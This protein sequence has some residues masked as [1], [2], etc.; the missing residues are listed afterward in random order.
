LVDDNY[1]WLFS[2]AAQSI[3]ALIG[4]LLAGVAL[5][6]S[7]MDRL[8]EQHETREETVNSYRRTQHW[9]LTALAILTGLAILASLYAVLINP[10]GM[11]CRDIVRIIAGVLDVLAII[12]SI[13]FVSFIVRPDRYIKAAKHEYNKIRSGEH[14]KRPDGTKTQKRVE[15][16][17]AFFRE[18]IELEQS[19]RNYIVKLNFPFQH[20]GAKPQMSLREMLE[21]LRQIEKISQPLMDQL[22]TVNRLRNLIFHGRMESVDEDVL[23]MLRMAR[24]RWDEETGQQY[25]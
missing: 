6:F 2:A 11:G 1:Y 5:A 10:W 16:A 3:A 17:S 24:S 14:D 7:L 23:K 22:L 18:F 21:F 19:V 8:I 4:F 12:F 25:L 15:P 13:V 20:I 9:Q